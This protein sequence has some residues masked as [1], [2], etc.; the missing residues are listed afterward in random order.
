[1]D[2]EQVQNIE[3][4]FTEAVENFY[5]YLGPIERAGYAAISDLLEAQHRKSDTAILILSTYGGDP[6]A[7][8]RIA[9]ALHHHY[10]NFKILLPDV[11]KSAGTLVC[12]G[13]DELIFGDRAEL[14]PLDVQIAKPN[15][16][17]GSMSGLD[18]TQALLSLQDQTIS[19]FRRFLVEITTGAGLSTKMASDIATKL[20]EGYVAPISAKIDPV[21]LGEHHRAIQIAYAYGKRLEETSH[22][23]HPGALIKLVTDY[24]AHGFVIDRKEARSLF[25]LVSSPKQKLEIV[26]HWARFLIE[27]GSYPEKAEVYDLEQEFIRGEAQNES[28]EKQPA[29]SEEQYDTSDEG[30]TKSSSRKGV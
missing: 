21:T 10:E 23:L 24:P 17:Y 3:T 13:A 26:Y 12:I 15:E 25:K 30:D 19:G 6:D 2:D 11:C 27:N 28:I 4:I 1:M 16:L 5:F 18:I 7:A 22:S 8:F 14:G 29:S 20:V 9:R